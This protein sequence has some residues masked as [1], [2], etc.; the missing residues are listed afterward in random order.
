MAR[1]DGR[2]SSRFKGD[3]LPVENV[4]WNDAKEFCRKLS[5]MTGK[6][7]RLPTE[8]EWEYACRAKTTGAYA[9]DLDAMA[10]YSKNS[11]SRTH[12]VGQK[13]PNAFGLYDM[14]GNVWEWCEDVWHDNYNGAPDDGRAWVDIS[15]RGS[16]R[17]VR[18]G[19]WNG[20]AV[21]CR[22]AFRVWVTPGGR[23][24]SLGFRLLR[25]YR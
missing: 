13:Q 7:Y 1:G 12:P 10:W 4:S 11:D 21:L 14:H 6:E 2:Q 15:A 5:Q 8:A 9:G 25:T 19:G 22:S 18:G 17:V 23:H 3:D 24:V 20:N 16:Y